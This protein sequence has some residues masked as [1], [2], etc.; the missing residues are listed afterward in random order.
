MTC[1]LHTHTHTPFYGHFLGKSGL[2]CC[3]F[4]FSPPRM[5]DNWLADSC[6]GW[7]PFLSPNQQCW[8]TEAITTVMHTSIR[9]CV[10]S[11]FWQQY[12]LTIWCSD[13]KKM[14]LMSV[15]WHSSCAN[16]GT[17]IK[18]NMAAGHATGW[19]TEL[20]FYISCDTK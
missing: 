20:R 3:A 1:I 16:L 17:A 14:I 8:S 19:L 12:H 18:T 5:R 10:K 11:K 4:D 6:T 13:S 15:K 9:Q 2:V 7:M